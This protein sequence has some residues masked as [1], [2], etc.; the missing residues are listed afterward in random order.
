MIKLLVGMSGSFCNHEAVFKVLE[1]LKDQMEIQFVLTEN[2]SHTSTRFFQLE[3]FIGICEQISQK[4]LITTLT[5]AELIGP[6]DPYDIMLIAPATANLL[7]R[8]ATGAYDCPVALAAKA[9]I[10]N[11]KNVVIALA[12]NDILG[13]SSHNVFTLYNSK[14]Y[15]FVPFG[16]DNYK[17]KPQSC[18]AYFDLIEQTLQKALLNEQI[19]PVLME[20]KDE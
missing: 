10:R 2:V 14:P 12:S 8:L 13:T 4:P 3:E 5:Q 18:V 9:M 16:Q 7:S 19:Q 17:Q 20:K 6:R 1:K 15:Y 11:H